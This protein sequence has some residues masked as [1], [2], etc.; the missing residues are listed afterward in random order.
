MVSIATARTR[1]SPRCCWTSQTSSSSSA[2]ALTPGVSS[3]RFSL[4]RTTVIAWLISGRRSGNTASI[5]T[6]WISSIRPTLGA[7]F[8]VAFG[9]VVVLAIWFLSLS[10]FLNL[11]LG[12]RSVPASR[13]GR[14]WAPAFSLWESLA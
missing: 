4:E 3:S 9:S 13:S 7:P 1:S 6:P 14:R 8:W 5:T 2:P 10:F 12:R 11:G